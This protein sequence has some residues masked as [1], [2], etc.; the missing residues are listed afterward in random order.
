MAKSRLRD[1]VNAYLANQLVKR[2]IERLEEDLEK[3]E[4]GEIQVS[5]KEVSK[6]KGRLDVLKSLFSDTA[7]IEVVKE[8]EPCDVI[9]AGR[10]LRRETD[11]DRLID[12]EKDSFIIMSGL[13]W[14]NILQNKHHGII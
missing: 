1:E 14:D 3:V 10:R 12:L 9:D 4:K 13:A 7:V 8:Y 6:A 5:R 11:Y 2:R